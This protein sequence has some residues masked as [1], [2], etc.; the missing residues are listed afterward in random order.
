MPRRVPGSGSA[1]CL[2]ER[3]DG[4]VMDP[5]GATFLQ[6]EA[7]KGHDE[8]SQ[9]PSRDGDIIFV[10][11][12]RHPSPPAQQHVLR[13]VGPVPHARSE[14]SR[15]RHRE[16]RRRTE[17]GVHNGLHRREHVRAVALV[18]FPDQALPSVLGVQGDF[19]RAAIL[20]RLEHPK[21]HRRQGLS[22]S[23]RPEQPMQLGMEVSLGQRNGE[24]QCRP[25]E[26][27]L[28]LHHAS[29]LM[30]GART[31]SMGASGRPSMTLTVPLMRFCGLSCLMR[32]ARLPA[33][34]HEH[35]ETKPS[36]TASYGSCECSYPSYGT[37]RYGNFGMNGRSS[38][39]PS[40][41]NPAAASGVKL[42]SISGYVTPAIARSS[43]AVTLSNT[44]RPSGNPS[45]SPPSKPN[46]FALPPGGLM[47]ESDA[48]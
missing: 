25:G 29:T 14:A 36:V 10:Q 35:G 18:H 27:P 13:F 48:S 3:V 1:I 45:R 6:A 17:A 15:S 8:P 20:V 44:R 33:P 43:T 38:F 37:A 11:V 39:V 22:P 21:A 23:A 47:P 16:L 28:G 19:E 30:S 31:I 42:L 26:L 4:S 12:D 7:L 2:K 9:V 24:A 32:I 46:R 34:N 5:G 41:S 40:I